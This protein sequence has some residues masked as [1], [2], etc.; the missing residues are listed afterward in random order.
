[1]AIDQT[2]TP[3]TQVGVLN[4]TAEGYSKIA[5]LAEAFKPLILNGTFAVGNG[6]PVAAPANG[7]PPFYIDTNT[8][9]DTLYWWSAL[10]LPGAW[11][12]IGTPASALTLPGGATAPNTAPT[13]LPLYIQ[14]GATGG[15]WYFNAGLLPAPGQWVKVA[16]ADATAA[17]IAA[18]NPCLAPAISAAEL[19]ALAAAPAT[20]K[21]TVCI[22]VGSNLKA[23][24]VAL[25]DLPGAGGGS[26][27]GAFD[28]LAVGA[29]VMCWMRNMTA[30][31]NVGAVVAGD[32]LWWPTEALGGGGSS[33]APINIGTAAQTWEALTTASYGGG[34]GVASYFMPFKR[35]T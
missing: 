17:M 21:V 15:L 30:N 23:V 5:D 31:V 12:L 13:G 27:G 16:D 4:G 22:P 10:P 34:P 24:A 7:V 35:L 3:A 18:I 19:A 28:S 8:A 20:G 1:M 29:T 14:S 11:H 26:G 6:A 9:P 2:V 32:D 25:D 33:V